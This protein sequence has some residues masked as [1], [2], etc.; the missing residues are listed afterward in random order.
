MTIKP[1]LRLRSVWLRAM[2]VSLFV[3]ISVP[4]QIDEPIGQASVGFVCARNKDFD[5]EIFL[6]Q[7]AHS[8][9]VPV[10]VVARVRRILND[11]EYGTPHQKFLI[12]L[13]NGTSVLVAHNTKVAPRVPI[14]VDDLVTVCGDYVWNRQG[15]L[16]HWTHRSHSPRHRSGWIKYAGSLYQ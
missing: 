7:E 9:N 12:E 13:S 15:G 4:W 2:L 3:S 8:V 16:I 10:I 14:K 5:K 11:D 6:A 1:N